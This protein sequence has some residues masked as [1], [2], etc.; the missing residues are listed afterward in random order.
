MK[1]LSKEL[2]MKVNLEEYEEGFWFDGGKFK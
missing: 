1:D 2:E